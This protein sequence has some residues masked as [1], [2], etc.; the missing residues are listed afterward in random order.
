MNNELVPG[1]G[2]MPY[3]SRNYN[4]TVVMFVAFVFFFLN[5]H[6]FEQFRTWMRHG[7][8][9]GLTLD[10]FAK[11]VLLLN[12]RLIVGRRHPSLSHDQF[13]KG[14]RHFNHLSLFWFKELLLCF[15]LSWIVSNYLCSWII[16]LSFSNYSKLL[17]ISNLLNCCSIWNSRGTL[18][19]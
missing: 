14:I 12:V 13:C 3:F 1:Q 16:L 2:S 19:I 8:G 5:V 10:F 6:L 7:L 17:L 18:L 4:F 11:N 15:L 9:M